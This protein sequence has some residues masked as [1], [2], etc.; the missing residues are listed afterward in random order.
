MKI[1]RTFPDARR[2]CK[3]R[4]MA[5]T[6]VRAILIFCASSAL[7]AAAAQEQAAPADWRNVAAGLPIP[8]EGYCD[9]PYV[10]ITRDG[11]WLC[12]MTTGPGREGQRGQHVVSTTS[13]DRGRTWSKPVDI[14]PSNGPEASWATP[15]VT[16]AGRVY[17]FYDYNGDGVDSLRGK[18]ARAD[19]L[20]WYVYR[21]SDDGGLS[22]SDDRYRVPVRETACDRTNDWSGKVQIFWGISKPII[23]DGSAIFAFTKLGKHL[24]DN[25]EGWFFRCDNI[26]TETEPDNLRWEMLPDGDH[27]LRTAVRLG[28]GRAQHRAALRRRPVLHIPLHD[29]S[30]L[31]V[32]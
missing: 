24:L 4:C 8:D 30:P 6:L 1:G 31:P 9:Q 20:G 26:L 7:A 32:L 5:G 29:R 10:V 15:L 17:V 27:G 2:A 23:T 22:W 19:M 13:K 14:E 21:Y 12:V 18:P 3:L 25:G 16:P 11:A 28:A